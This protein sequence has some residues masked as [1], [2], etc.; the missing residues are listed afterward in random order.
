M[1]TLL[2]ITS[3]SKVF[4]KIGNQISEGLADGILGNIGLIQGA[5][6]VAVNATMAP[7]VAALAPTSTSNTT[8]NTN[9]FSLA[10]SSQARSEQVENSFRLME[11]L[12]ANG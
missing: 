4:M 1:K 8:T 7:S 3:P 10:I 6:E 9:H 2:G 11:A 12:A 5:A